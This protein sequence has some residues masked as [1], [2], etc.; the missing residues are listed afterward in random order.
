ME[1]YSL[2]PAALPQQPALHAAD[3]DAHH[4]AVRQLSAACQQVPAA[5]AAARPP[6]PS[7]AE[8]TTPAPA[9]RQPTHCGPSPSAAPST[10]RAASEDCACAARSACSSAAQR[11]LRASQWRCLHSFVNCICR[12]PLLKSAL[13]SV[14]LRGGHPGADC[15]AAARGSPLG[16]TLAQ[17]LALH[18]RA[19]L[20][21]GEQGGRFWV[22]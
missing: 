14:E 18:L 5:P 22:G 13:L 1:R 4:L 20:P 11:T 8:P 16:W 17:L 19:R 6:S 15:A 2:P 9:L 21:T 3:P 7:C 12:S 10:A